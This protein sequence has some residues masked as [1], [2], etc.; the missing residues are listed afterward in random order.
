[1]KVQSFLGLEPLNGSGSRSL[2]LDMEGQAWMTLL[3][4]MRNLTASASSELTARVSARV[5]SGVSSSAGSTCA[6]LGCV[7]WGEDDM[8]MGVGGCDRV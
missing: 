5:S 8:G 3:I 2:G 7:D 6:D 4:A 1:M